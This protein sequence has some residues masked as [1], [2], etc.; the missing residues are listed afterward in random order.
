MQFKT[1]IAYCSCTRCSVVYTI[2]DSIF[3]KNPFVI[4]IFFE[5]NSVWEA[6]KST[7]PQLKYHVLWPF[8]LGFLK[9]SLTISEAIFHPGFLTS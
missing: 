2:V 1:Q 9:R 7:F 5:M 4:C 3:N 6:I 8:A